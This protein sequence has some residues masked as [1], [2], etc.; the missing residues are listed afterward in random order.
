MRVHKRSTSFRS[1]AQFICYDHFK[2]INGRY[3]VFLSAQQYLSKK[4]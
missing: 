4:T 3:T 1:S 2:L